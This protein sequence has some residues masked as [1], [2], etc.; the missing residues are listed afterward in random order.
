M[1]QR[2]SGFTLIEVMITLV[3]LFLV[4]N[5]LITFF[6]GVM[7]QYKQ[8]S[9]IAET[10]VETIMGLELLRQDIGHAGFGLPWNNLPNY[11]EATSTLLNDSPSNPPRPI[12]SINN[13]ASTFNNHDYLVIKSTAVGM[14]NASNKWTTLMLGNV[15]RTW[16]DNTDNMDGSDRVIVL[17]PGSGASTFRAVVSAGGAFSTTYGNTAA[18]SPALASDTR[19]VYGIDG[20][21]ANPLRMPFT[22]ADYS[23]DNTSVPRH[24][25]PNTGVLVKSVVSQADG[26]L[27]TPL[28]L[29]DC[30]ASMQVVYR[31]DTDGNG[32]I[33]ATSSDI[34]GLTAQQIREQLIEVRVYLLS[35]E[36]QKDSSYTHSPTTMY[37]GDSGIGGGENFDIG[38]NRNYRW[39]VFSLA[40]NT[41]NLGN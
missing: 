36:G 38:A 31:M 41:T 10:G 15:K 4:M 37:V 5:A 18:F 29:L 20:P 26:S 27:S 9:K 21:S 23:I 16:S 34:S 32:T 40:V 13:A 39:K 12:V 25:A 7:R 24:C 1:R 22:R 19:V 14:S 3:I 28:P 33:D 6:I 2:T 11:N 8:Q 30:V 35:H 17:A